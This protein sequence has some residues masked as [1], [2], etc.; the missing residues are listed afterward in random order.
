MAAIEYDPSRSALYTPEKQE[1][2]FQAGKAYSSLQLAVE[3]AR[4][5]YIH[6]EESASERQRLAD[7]LERVG[8]AG[9]KLFGDRKTDTQGFGAYR[10]GDRT[11]LIGFRGTQPDKVTDVAT[12]LEAHQVAWHE[13]GGNV[14]GG[15]AEAARSVMPQVEDWLKA[16]SAGRARLILTGHSLGAAV[17]TLV[18]SVVRPTA[19]ITLGSPRVGDP[20]FA[21]TFAGMGGTRIVDCC[22]AVTEVPPELPI[23]THI[24]PPTYIT[25]DGATLQNPSAEEIAKD[26]FHGRIEYFV[27]YAWK[28]GSVFVRDLAD[29]APINYARAFF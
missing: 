20:T 1:T 27:K 17:A 23:Y 4:L 22:D 7:A 12:D 13:S 26:R 29:H 9:L 18:A 8:F 24:R 21:T 19:L 2:I 3:A 16:E 15:F 25:K 11:A 14:H 10:S 6:A 5:A 28:I